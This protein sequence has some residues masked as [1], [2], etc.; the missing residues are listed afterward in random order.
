MSEPHPNRRARRRK[1]RRRATV[2]SVLGEIMLTAGVVVLMFVAWQMWIGDMIQ[3][4]QSNQAGAAT[5]EEWADLPDDAIAPPK[6]V[7]PED[8]TPAYY[9]PPVMAPAASGETFAV[10]RIPRLGDNYFWDINGGVQ[11]W[12]SLNVGAVGHYPATQMPGEVGNFAVAGHRGSHG[13]AFMNLPG[14]RAGDAVVVE[15]PDGWYTY[16]F[17]NLEYVAP[18][19][20]DVLAPVPHEASRIGIGQ[21]LTMTT[22]SPR[23]G[24]D[25][26]AIG[27]AEFEYFTP[28]SVGEPASLDPV[29]VAV[30]F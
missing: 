15:T 4:A 13:G 5:V 3:G 11:T 28:R 18:T 8:G 17:R 23:Y 22:C 20:G 9:E 16:R 7:Q 1:P 26:R 12:E 30:G 14:M 10:L 19:A 6:L 29:T 27:Y 2:T 21:Y 24:W 25:E